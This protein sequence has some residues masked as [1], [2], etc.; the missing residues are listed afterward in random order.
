MKPLVKP[1]NNK[2][3]CP[4]FYPLIYCAIFVNEAMKY[5]RPVEPVDRIAFFTEEEELASWEQ[6]YRFEVVFVFINVYCSVLCMRKRIS[7]ERHPMTHTRHTFL[8][9]AHNDKVDD[10]KLCQV[11]SAKIVVPSPLL[12]PIRVN[13]YSER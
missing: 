9:R 2:K 4:L 8:I 7:S 6:I 3:R 12:A 1:Y 10:R 5:T 13:D 11:L